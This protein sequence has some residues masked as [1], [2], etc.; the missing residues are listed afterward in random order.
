MATSPQNRFLSVLQR[1]MKTPLKAVS[2]HD[3][4][5]S[6]GFMDA[7]P[8]SL[9]VL[10]GAGAT[11]AKTRQQLY[12]DWQGMLEDP[13][14][15]TALS[16]H[17]TAALGGHESRGELVFIEP[18]ADVKGNKEMEGVVSE[19]SD[20]L[21]DIFN[22]IAGTVAYNGVSF[23]DAYGRIYGSQGK[24]VADVLVDELVYPPLVQ[25]YEQGNK[26]VA[27][28]IATGERNFERLNVAQMARLKMP[29]T[30]YIPQQ[31]VIEKAM[32]ASLKEDDPMSLPAMPSLVGGSFLRGAEKPYRR[33]SS[34]LAGMVSSNIA[35]ALDERWFAVNYSGMTVDQRQAFKKSFTNLLM[36]SKALT[37]KMVS[38]GRYNT[39]KFFGVLPVWDA[40]QVTELNTAGGAAGRSQAIGATPDEVIMHARMLSGA[41]GIDLSM[42]GFADQLSGGL[43]D[44][45]FFRMSAHAA[46]RSRVIRVSLTEF[47]DHIVR[48][49]LIYKKGTSYDITKKPWNINFFGSISALQAENQRTKQ[50]AMNTGAVLVQVLAQLRD[51]NLGKDAVRELLENEMGMDADRAELIANSLKPPENGG[52]FGDG[53]GGGF[54]SGGG[55]G[56][57]PPFAENGEP[58]NAGGNKE[59]E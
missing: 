53:G 21:S 31:R 38:E 24:G 51:L 12:L 34:A 52:G 10:L 33:M 5:L 46:E 49:H 25:P 6:D 2:H 59:G 1:F 8:V 19:I 58:V 22:K 26:T 40:K 29:R 4:P 13:I 17:V 47:F 32:R 54:G 11:T 9:S 18:A 41:L 42:L 45:G 15:S 27:Y 37:D 55:G 44:G 7:D 57:I 43:G 36:Q 23:G 39:G 50:D 48:V 56:P 30:A 16:L 3:D 14:V 28:R 35:N 20:D